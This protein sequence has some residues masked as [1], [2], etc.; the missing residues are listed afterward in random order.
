MLKASTAFLAKKKKFGKRK[1]LRP[2]SVWDDMARKVLKDRGLTS[3][4]GKI[5]GVPLSQYKN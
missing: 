2:E 3:P 1:A 4:L 5:D